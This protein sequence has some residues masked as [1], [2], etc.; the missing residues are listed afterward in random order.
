VDRTLLLKR[1]NVSFV[2][3]RVLAPGS[4]ATPLDLPTAVV[5][6]PP[7]LADLTSAV[8]TDD[9]KVFLDLDGDSVNGKKFLGMRAPLPLRYFKTMCL[10][11]VYDVVLQG[12]DTISAW[13]TRH[14][15]LGTSNEDPEPPAFDPDS[16]SHPYHQHINHF[17]IQGFHG[18]PVSEDFI[19]IGEWRDTVGQMENGTVVRTK[20]HRYVGEVMFH[21]HY[22]EH[23]DM[24]MMGAFR[25]TE[26]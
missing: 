15:R 10:D 24:G 26:C 1:F 12:S 11:V 19:R 16:G 6:L 7:Y 17:Q 23:S 4:I 8:T 18:F 9:Q 3:C 21:C 25:V 20:P 14:R 22:H 13:P 2:V 5:S